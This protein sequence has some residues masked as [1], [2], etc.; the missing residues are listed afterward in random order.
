MKDERMT[1]T[2][3]QQLLHITKF[4][5]YQHRALCKFPAGYVAASRPHAHFQK[6]FEFTRVYRPPDRLH[7][8]VVASSKPT[9]TPF[10]L[11]TLFPPSSPMDVSKMDLKT[12]KEHKG[13]RVS[14][15]VPG[16][17][18]KFHNIHYVVRE[19]RG[20]CRKRGPER[21]ILKDVSGIMRTGLNAIMGATG[22][23]KTSEFDDQF[24]FYEPIFKETQI[25]R[26]NEPFIVTHI[27]LITCVC[28]LLDV[29]AGRKDPRGLRSGQILV[30]NKF[31]TS[32][33]RLMSA[34]VVQD[35]I[36]MGTLS[37]RENLLFS[38]NLR[39][40]RHEYSVKE[41][42]KKVMS[43]IK[44]LGLEDCANTKIGTEFLRGVS[45]GERKRCSIGMELITSPSLL[46]LDEPTTGL[47]S[48]TAN[49]I[50]GLLHRLSRSGKTII[51]SIHQP[52][53]SI[54]RLFDHLT[55]LHKGEM[56]Y[57]GPAKKAIEYFHNLGYQCEP[58]NNP[59]DFFLDI[60]NGETSPSV[61]S[62]KSLAQHYK[63]SQ[64]NAGVME[65]LMQTAGSG[66]SSVSATGAPP[67]Y[68]TPFHY[69]LKIVCWRALLNLL[70]N[71][72]TSYAQIALNICFAVLVGLIYFQ[73][74]HT[75]PEALQNRTGAFFFL[76]INMV[77]G[78]LSAVELF[79]GERA[80]FVHENSG[81]YYRTS[82]YFL[83]KVFVDLIPNRIIPILIFS[84][85]AYYMMGLKPDFTA[86]LRFS[87]TLSMVSMAAVSLAF[88]ASASVSSFAMAN[89]FIAL[90][91]VFMMLQW[92]RPY[93]STTVHRFTLFLNGQD[94]HRTATGQLSVGSVLWAAS[95]GQ[96][97]LCS[98]L[99]AASCGQRPV[100][101]FLWAAFCGQRPVGSFLWAASSVQRPVRCVLRTASC[102]QHPVGS[103]LWAGSCGQLPVTS[104]L[105][106]G[107][108]GQLP[109]GS[110]LRAASCGQHPEGSVLWVAS[111][112][113]RP[114][115]RVLW[116]AS[117]GQL[118]VGSVLWAASCGQR[119][120]GSVM[121]AASCGQLPVGSVLWVASCGRRPL[122]SDLSVFGGFLVNLNAMLNWLSWLKWL[123]IFKYGLDAVTI[124]EM[125]GQVFT[126]NTTKY[127]FVY[128]QH[129]MAE[130]VPGA[131]GSP[132]HSTL[133][134]VGSPIHS[135]L[136]LVGSPIHST[137]GLVGS[138]IH[139]TL[140]LVG[141]PILQQS[142]GWWEEIEQHPWAGGTLSGHKTGDGQPF[143]EHPWAG[144]K[145][146]PQHPW[147]GAKPCPQHPWAGGK[148]HPQHPWAG[149]KPY[150]QHPW[151][152]G[153]PYP[154]H[155]W[156]GGKLHPQHPWADG[157][158]YPQHPWAGGKPYPQ[159]PWAGGKPYPQ[160]P[161]AGGKP[162][163]QHPWAGGKP[164]PQHPW[165]GGKPYPQ[166]PWAG[167]KPY[168]QHPWA[169]GQP[170]PQHP[171]AGGKPIHSTLGLMDRPIH[172]TLGLMGS[173]VYSTLGLVGSPVHSTLGLVGSP[174]HSTLGLDGLV[175]NNVRT[176]L[177][178]RIT[179]EMYL[180]AQGIDYSVWG[181]WQNQV[182][183]LGITLV[184]ITLTYVQLRRINR[185]K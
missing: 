168:P 177:S 146:L 63:D 176:P 122:G 76:V 65:E 90:P 14:V 133:G 53:Y 153:K 5:P 27:P 54:F 109:V 2:A 163:P 148:P 134:L 135:T 175:S 139:S 98:I 114:E 178:F 38:A 17:T 3:Q 144:G 117:C 97:P 75:L 58:F 86:F 67:A 40:P 108:C 50:I 68:I 185:W 165:A 70:R 102:V 87:L 112:G 49:S 55:L 130:R 89:I 164:Y 138:P 88:L 91:F 152:G 62:D 103:V 140:G 19:S 105:W 84:A 59:A 1:S 116:A 29:I 11:Q 16:P 166:H 162:Y 158:A 92:S 115:G 57:A 159:H 120:V 151:T 78:N 137:L 37:V 81:G 45:G 141:S 173:H 66:D 123:S 156:A 111:C 12:F 46:F 15:D 183:L 33:L 43:I 106:A 7:E 95:C 39:L 21:D 119:P 94:P 104:V 30:D 121:R 18:L 157:Q 22:S 9:S 32:E 96:L 169:G 36:L 93:R 113:Q 142:L 167:G 180:K 99:W 10:P 182:A 52:R 60:T 74:S 129:D 181:F 41:K 179:G 172:S 132:I 131:V 42:K 48:N 80:L 13:E 126:D 61:P 147:A 161:W 107:S 85:I 26:V 51:F 28:S 149:G 125:T 20:P 154:Q 23:G 110:V 100:G 127:V 128:T 6:D 56:V 35:D 143:P 24:T 25:K 170:Y 150:P 4:R 171:W 71:P 118:P 64:Y 72:Q 69:Q 160:H 47:D 145:P 44:D 155:P 174:I 31:V 79:I 73:M 83:S 101:S 8:G 82:V 124:N 34:Y 184:C 77:F 136:G